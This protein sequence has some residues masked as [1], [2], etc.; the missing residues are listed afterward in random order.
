MNLTYQ[1]PIVGEIRASVI[2]DCYII[3]Q[4]MRKQDKMSAWSVL[5]MSPLEMTMVSF[6]KSLVTMTIVHEI[7]IA[8][9]GIM[10]RDLSSGILWM[11]TT[12]GIEENGFGRPFVRN[13]RKW[14]N[15]MLE[16]YP[17]LIG[18]VDLRN[19]VSIKWLTYLGCEW[20]ITIPYG[21]D[22]MPFRYFS[23]YRRSSL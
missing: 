15:D 5:R 4:N 2:D 6:K 8:I 21:I 1:D 3:A 16:I 22:K 11:V 17:H 12:N 23:F 18:L 20:G 10:P 19:T 13:C 7:P 9:F 14:F